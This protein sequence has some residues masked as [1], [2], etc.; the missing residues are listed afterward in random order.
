MQR[1][2]RRRDT[3]TF[4]TKDGNWTSDI[5]DAARFSD[6]KKLFEAIQKLRGGDLEI[7]FSFDEL[8]TH[9]WDFTLPLTEAAPRTDTPVAPDP[10]LHPMMPP[11]DPRNPH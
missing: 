11:P 8:E 1:L 6:R 9:R 7:Y 2:I 4:L 5:H 3:R 10:T